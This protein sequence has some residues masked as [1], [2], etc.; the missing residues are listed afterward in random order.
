MSNQQGISEQVCDNSL[1]FII[2]VLKRRTLS[3]FWP[4]LDEMVINVPKVKAFA[5]WYHDPVLRQSLTRTLCTRKSQLLVERTSC[6]D[7]TRHAV[8]A[9]FSNTLDDG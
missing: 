3:L 1:V 5:P 7:G 2:M 6:H 4:T 9:R 8:L